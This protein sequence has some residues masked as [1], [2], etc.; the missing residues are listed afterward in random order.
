MKKTLLVIFVLAVAAL[1]FACEKNNPVVQSSRNSQTANE[2]FSPLTGSSTIAS[3]TAHSTEDNTFPPEAIR[4]DPDHTTRYRDLYYGMFEGGHELFADPYA[5]DKLNDYYGRDWPDEMMLVTLIKQYDVPKNKF[6]EAVKAAAKKMISRG[7]DLSEEGCELPNA[8]I[9]Y[10][11]DNEIIDAY[12]RR[13]NPVAP[14]WLT[15]D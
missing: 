10:T 13:E 9:L 5:F 12:Y 3:H 6:E 1:L 4:L 15:F 2:S 11:F 8:D 7:A 14:E